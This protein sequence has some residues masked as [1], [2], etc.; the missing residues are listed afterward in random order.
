MEA[1]LI[2]KSI[3]LLVVLHAELT[4]QQVVTGPE[5]VRTIQN[6]THPFSA[7]DPL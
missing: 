3:I 6:S 4:G 1:G 2:L 7:L 5:S